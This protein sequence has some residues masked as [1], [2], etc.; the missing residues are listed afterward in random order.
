M[1]L[2]LEHDDN[3]TFGT[4]QHSAGQYRTMMVTIGEKK[5]N[6]WRTVEPHESA[7]HYGDESYMREIDRA[8][9]AAMEQMLTKLFTDACAAVKEGAQLL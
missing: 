3:L 4:F 6:V 5:F 7:Y 1:R 2:K 9:V 8:L